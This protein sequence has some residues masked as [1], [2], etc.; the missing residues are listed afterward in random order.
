MHL[1]I[2][3]LILVVVSAWNIV[4]IL[5]SIAS[6]LDVIVSYKT[7]LSAG[8]PELHFLAAVVQNV[9]KGAAVFVSRKRKGKRCG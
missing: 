7:C 4:N 9:A 8:V 3:I 5:F 1:N 2:Y 6:E